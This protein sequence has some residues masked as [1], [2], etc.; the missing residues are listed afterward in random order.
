MFPTLADVLALPP[1]ARGAPRVRVGGDRLD[2]PVRW[3]HVSE[4]PDVAGTLTGDELLLSTGIVLADVRVD[5]DAYVRSLCEGGAAALCVEL[6][7]HLPE[8]PDAVVRSARRRGLP[9]VEFGR[10]VRFVEITEVV[11]SRILHVQYERLRF[12]QRVH[13]AFDTLGIESPPVGDVL[14]RAAEL[15]GQPVVLEDLAHHA[16]AFAG[17]V[18]V[19][20][21][22]RDWE[23]RSRLAPSA[24][25]TAVGG[26]ERWTCTP[27]GP[28]RRRW[29][30]LVV[31][32]RHAGDD[33]Q[34]ALVLERAAE[35]IAIGRLVSG[36]GFDVTREAQGGLLHEL[37]AGR[38]ADESALRSRMRALGLR[39]GRAYAVLVVALPVRADGTYS[40]EAER[41][42]ADT[43]ASTAQAQG[44]AGLTGVVAPGRVAVIL[45]C[46]GVSHEPA[47]VSALATGVRAHAH[48]PAGVVIGASMPVTRLGRLSAAL[49]EAS[50]VADVAAMGRRSRPVHRSADLGVHGLLWCF[51][52]DPRLAAFSETVLR[53]LLTHDAEHRSGLMDLLRAH[54]EA[55]GNTAELA[56]AVHLSRPAVYGRL[57]RLGG[58]LGADVSDPEVRRTL[59]VALLA[60]E[61]AERARS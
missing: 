20:E 4:I 17:P 14:A 56:R 21:L 50:H 54:L 6:G 25:H 34:L 19:A 3:V 53:P 35:A 26:P 57:K 37:L 38:P 2:R 60:Y 15:S 13:E 39:T 49:E 32:L 52:D 18:P 55:D 44:R 48:T 47:A 24:A 16:V 12:A 23:D 58:V 36:D 42:V 22:L 59:W 7:R 11:H 1:V 27:V 46:A 8:L 43:A 51:R 5:V 33:D 31:P 28:R 41:A 29:G 61:Q 40:T 30:R 45:P 10:T 9:L